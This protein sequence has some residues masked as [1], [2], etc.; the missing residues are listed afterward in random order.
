MTSIIVVI[1]AFFVMYLIVYVRQIKKKKED[2]FS[3]V[4]EFQNDY[5]KYQKET[6]QKHGYTRNNKYTYKYVT[7]YNS[8]EDYREKR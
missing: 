2:E 6:P 3:S 8:S 7:K 5:K 1:A 4:E